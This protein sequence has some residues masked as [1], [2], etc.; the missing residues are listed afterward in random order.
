[1]ITVLVASGQG[2]KWRKQ[3]VIYEPMTVAI[4]H[5]GMEM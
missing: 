3:T 1:M 5:G 4:S 2:E